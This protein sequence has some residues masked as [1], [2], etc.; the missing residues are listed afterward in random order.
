MQP[1]TWP[2]ICFGPCNLY[3]FPPLWKMDPLFM[4]E[5]ERLPQTPPTELQLPTSKVE[6]AH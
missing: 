5:L 2:D 1:I 6:A 3:S 4:R